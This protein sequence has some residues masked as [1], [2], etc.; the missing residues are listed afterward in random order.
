MCNVYLHRLDRAWDTCEHGV[1]VR[2]CDDLVVMCRSRGQ[3][4]AALKRLTV[5]LG[6]LGLAPKPSKTRIVHLA[7]GGE[8][9][10][11]WASTI[12]WCVGGLPG[13]R[14]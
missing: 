11:S 10:I 8:G 7:E 3:A 6:E 2:Y 4:E 9:V 12:D 5:L 14:I 13:R 1:L